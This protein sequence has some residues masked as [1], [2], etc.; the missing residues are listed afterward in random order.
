VKS[1]FYPSLPSTQLEA[2]RL[3]DSGE[4]PP[5]FVVAEEQTEGRGRLDR[6][7]FSERGRSLTLTAVFELST[8]EL[9]ALSLVVGL[10]LVKILRAE[11]LKLKWPNDLIL[12]DEKIGGILIQSRS[13]GGRSQCVMGI[14]LNL[15]DLQNSSYKGL[16]LKVTAEEIVE[17][18]EDFV[19]IFAS[20]G[21]STFRE[22][23]ERRMWRRGE[24][25]RLQTEGGEV[26]ATILGVAES[27][28][29][30]TE[31][32]GVLSLTENGE[33]SLG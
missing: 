13:L 3:L 27:G 29:L 30:K 32:H 18:L 9:S 10:S 31:S 20:S 2:F 19:K 8:R 25:V 14:G 21:F 28:S 11:D 26:E 15:L 6:K 16:N 22:D 12:G 24:V 33:I 1:F 17:S 5:F 4:S 23:F 7:W